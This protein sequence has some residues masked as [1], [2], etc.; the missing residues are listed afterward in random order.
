MKRK[1][2]T[3]I[4]MMIAVALF[5]LAMGGAIGVYVMCQKMWHATSLSML[6][7]RDAHFALLRLVYGMGTNSGLRAAATVAISSNAQGWRLTCSNKFDGAKSIDFHKQASN[8][9]WVDS[10][11]QSNRLCDHVSSAVVSTNTAG[12]NIR[13][14]LL[15][16][17][18]RFTS[19]NQVST[20]VLMRNREAP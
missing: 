13:L 10:V 9:Y 20:F 12:V 17:E 7:Q 15:R 16:T 14:T 1:G 6:T 8:I 5:G 19:T 11:S 2:F 4:E 18:G 3:L